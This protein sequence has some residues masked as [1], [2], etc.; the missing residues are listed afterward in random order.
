MGFWMIVV[1]L[2]LLILYKTTVGCAFGVAIDSEWVVALPP[3]S[4]AEMIV[5]ADPR[6]QRIESDCYHHFKRKNSRC[7]V[8]ETE[9]LVMRYRTYYTLYLCIHIHHNINQVYHF[10]FLLYI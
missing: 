5:D 4:P 6:K 2:I 7:V 9:L 1:W 10:S 8:S 3:F